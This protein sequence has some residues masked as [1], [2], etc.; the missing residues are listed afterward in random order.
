[1]DAKTLN[2]SHVQYC[3]P[4]LFFT[5]PLLEDLEYS[6]KSSLDDIPRPTTY[7]HSFPSFHF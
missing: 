1:L 6:G 7:F 3:N 5:V 4:D 2:L